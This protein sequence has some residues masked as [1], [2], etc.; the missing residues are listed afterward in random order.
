M[1]HVLVR[2]RHEKLASIRAFCFIRVVQFTA[3]FCTFDFSK[4]FAYV[5]NAY[6]EKKSWV[7][8][9]QNGP[10]IHLL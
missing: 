3:K 10:Y 4:S 7:S 2:T 1:E 6:K 9:G 5:N 8:T